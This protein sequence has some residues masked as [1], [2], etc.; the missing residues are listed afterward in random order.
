MC[1]QVMHLIPCEVEP[2]KSLLLIN[3]VHISCTRYLDTRF[4][5]VHTLPLCLLSFIDK[6]RFF[7]LLQ[8]FRGLIDGCQWLTPVILTS[9]EAE[10]RRIEVLAN[11]S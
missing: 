1:L 10:I 6:V 11:N 5:E 8:T 7:L 2:L 4:Y 9:L 3:N